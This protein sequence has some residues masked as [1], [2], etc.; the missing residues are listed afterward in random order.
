MKIKF[1]RF[2]IFSILLVSL[3]SC[4]PD[5]KKDNQSDNYTSLD[6]SINWFIWTN[7]NAYY[8]W[9]D[10]VTN[11]NENKFRTYQDLDK[12]LY[13]K[14]PEALFES[15]LYLPGTVDRFS[16]ITNNSK[17]LIDVLESGIS[18]SPGMNIQIYYK[19]DNRYNLVA[20][21]FYVVPNGPADQAGIKRGDI[22]GSING[23]NLN[24][25]NINTLLSLPQFKV[26]LVSYHGIWQNTGIEYYITSVELAENPILIDTVYEINQNN[27]VKKIAYLVYNQFLDIYDTQLNDIFGEFTQKGATEL[28]LDLR[29][30]AGGSLQSMIHLASMIKG[31]DRVLMA[32][33]S[34]NAEYQKFL[35]DTLGEDFFNIYF[36]DHIKSENG[37]QVM[38]NSMNLKK[39]VILT[40]QGTASASEILIFSLNPLISVQM[41]GDFTY[42]KFVGSIT[43]LDYNENGDLNPNHQWAIQPI[44]AEF[45]NSKNEKGPSEGLTPNFIKYEQPSENLGILGD[46]NEPFLSE[47]I[48]YIFKP[49]S[50]KSNTSKN[51]QLRWTNKTL[52][53]QNSLLNDKAIL[54]YKKLPGFK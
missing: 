18:V 12:F 30:N 54:D 50:L 1:N 11:L 9:T 5:D 34:Y 35:K 8:L 6:S 49:N 20:V 27:N 13:G 39:V 19:D 15:L 24:V 40:S 38:I 32:S 53:Y 31:T 4:E 10:L 23:S 46:I 37:D 25:D 42:G 36:T 44:V 51:N 41:I 52:R 17:E 28:I 43:L 45:V 2:F 14:K 21:V 47:A 29:Y 33:E 3:F 26:G 16:Y 48:S 7:M 22:I